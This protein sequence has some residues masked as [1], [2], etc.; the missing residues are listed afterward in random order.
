MRQEE[1]SRVWTG[2]SHMSQA[3]FCANF[4]Y[5]LNGTKGSNQIG[6][7]MGF[8][9]AFYPTDSELVAPLPLNKPRDMAVPFNE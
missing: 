9:T 4:V 5:D 3:Y 8:I 2:N 1:V 7:D 6:K